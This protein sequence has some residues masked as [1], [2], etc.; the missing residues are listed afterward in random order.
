MDPDQQRGVQPTAPTRSLLF[1][2]PLGLCGVSAVHRGVLEIAKITP[3]LEPHNIDTVPYR[4]GNKVLGYLLLYLSVLVQIL[5]LQ[6]CCVYLQ[7]SQ[8]GYLHQSIV[9][10]IAKL[11]GRSTV[12][13]F[14][15]QPFIAR[16][17]TANQ[18]RIIRWSRL[19]V[20]RFVVLSEQ[21]KSDL[22]A[23]GCDPARVSVIPNF[24]KID[25]YP[26]SGV[27][28]DERKYLLFIGRMTVAKGIFEIVELAKLLPTEKFVLL[29]PF[30]SD[31]VRREFLSA[32]ELTPN[33]KWHGPV[34]GDEK[35]PW[36]ANAKIT[37]LPSATEVFPMAF[38]ESAFCFTVTAITPVGM[39]PE[40]VQDGID[41]IFIQWEKAPGNAAILR[42]W[43]ANPEELEQLARNARRKVEERYTIDGVYRDLSSILLDEVTIST[44]R[45]NP[46][47]DYKRKIR[48]VMK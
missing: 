43:L 45:V 1:V 30:E 31:T 41:G 16:T 29:G 36:I 37:L 21:S 8:S 39:V 18:F 28:W 19:Y 14:H 13:H 26:R 24:L 35:I 48:M 27:C 11:L 42:R 33:V 3:N 4:K 46:C 44:L 47:R 12:A 20:N 34:Y 32:I 7:I 5:R 38:L 2:G 6:P 10:L 9:L 40:V 25:D 22:V 17:T 15:A 23:G